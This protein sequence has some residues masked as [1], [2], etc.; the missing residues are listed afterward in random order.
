MRSDNTL[1]TT[2]QILDEIMTGAGCN[3]AA[4]ARQLPSH[5]GER[6]CLDPST[7]W[8]WMTKGVRVPDGRQVRLEAAR[9]GG[10]VLTTKPA[11]RR[12]AE[13]Q[14]G[15]PAADPEQTPRTPSQRQRAA[16]LASQQL[17]TMGV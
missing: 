15:Q 12:F 8:R 2:E 5:R 14:S 10:R 6:S 13:A 3:C 1:F 16:D 17:E 4:A 11:L 7:I 9:I